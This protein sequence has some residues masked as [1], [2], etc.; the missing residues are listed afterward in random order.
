MEPT[1]VRVQL[2]YE[3]TEI[4]LLKRIHAFITTT[5][6]VS[7]NVL[8]VKLVADDD[9]QAVIMFHRSVP[10]RYGPVPVDTE[11]MVDVTTGDCEDIVFALEHGI[12][13]FEAIVCADRLENMMMVIDEYDFNSPDEDEEGDE[14]ASIELHSH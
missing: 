12:E 9:K 7:G 5:H 1:Q 11:V 2:K 8:E 6:G 3:P 14:P 13:R 10:F 4:R